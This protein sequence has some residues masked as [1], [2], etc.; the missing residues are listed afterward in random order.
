MGKNNKQRRAAKQRAR[1]RSTASGSPRGPLYDYDPASLEALREVL[2][3]AA[4]ALA[5]GDESV[6]RE[7]ATAMLG[8]GA[9]V[10]AGRPQ[11][12]L[13]TSFESFLPV[14]WQ[15]GWQPYDLDQVVRRRLGPVHREV[16]AA[17]L[18]QEI[19]AYPKST[20]DPRW[21]A[22]L[23]ELGAQP[24]QVDGVASSAAWSA[25]VA[26]APAE[27]FVAAL[28]LLALLITLGPIA[29]Q[30]PPPGKARTGG[31][32]AA[33][34]DEDER[35]LSRVRALL[36]KAESTS[37][38]EEAEAL[39]AKAQELM[40]RHS[41]HR[42]VVET[43]EHGETPIASR[44]LWLEAPYAGAKAMLVNQVAEANRCTAVWTEA[45]G[46]MTVVGHERDLSGVELLVTSLLVQATRAMLSPQHGS[47]GVRTGSTRSFRQSFL[48]A[49]AGRIGERLAGS[50]EAAVAE[51]DVP[52]LL[53]VLRADALRVEEERSR[54]FPALV[55]KTVSDNNYAGRIAGRAA[56]DAAVLDSRPAVRGDRAAS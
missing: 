1:Q 52:D 42:L 39:S 26:G 40:A 21:H 8:P 15:H 19:R 3:S 53:P 38:P 31:A 37:F 34:S 12:A 24:V 22:Q 47:V 55:Q 20:V 56:A 51:L 49:Y 13:G 48:V 54:L 32:T 10:P 18:A 50:S 36:A 46:F 14:L 29:I 45:L 11:Q 4:H 33:L 17:M 23:A 43:A 41:L 44:R 35:A 7:V 2:L 9:P 16:L 6:A 28:E 5:N 30:L 25:R 27:V